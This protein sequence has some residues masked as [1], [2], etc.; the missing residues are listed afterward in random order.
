M[1][2]TALATGMANAN[3]DIHMNLVAMHIILMD[4]L[5]QMVVMLAIMNM[6]MA[7]VTKGLGINVSM[8]IARC[9]VG[10]RNGGFMTR[11]TQVLYF[12]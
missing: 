10:W 7:I 3:L 11:S 6:A 4:I 5:M 1:G 12:K 8:S 9:K 2:M